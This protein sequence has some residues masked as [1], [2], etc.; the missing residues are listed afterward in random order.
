[1]IEEFFLGTAALLSS[2]NGMSFHEAE[3]TIPQGTFEIHSEMEF[4]SLSIFSQEE[5]LPNIEF[6][7]EN[8]EFEPWSLYEENEIEDSY[9]L[10][11]LFVGDPTNSI[12]IRSDKTANLVAHFY[13]TTRPG[14]KLVA[15]FDPFDDDS[16]DDPITGLS[17]EMNLKAPKYISRADW[18]ADESLRVWKTSKKISELFKTKWF[19]AEIA[20][21]PVK[22]RPKVVKQ[23]TEDGK[24]LYWPIA[25]SPH[26]AKFAIHHTG[27]Y[28][29]KERDPMEIMRAIYSFH[30]L[31]R[32]WGDIGYNYVIDKQGNIYEGRAGGPKSVGAHVAYHNIGTVGISLMGNFQTEK[33]TEAQ[34]KVLA[35]LLADHARRFDV[36]LTGK[37]E[38]FGKFT[39]NV[40]GHNEL[41]AAGHG[42]ACPGKYMIEKLPWLRKEAARYEDILLR[43]EK[44]GSTLGKDFLKKSK[45]APK[46]QPFKEFNIPDKKDPITISDFVEKQV[47]SRGERITIELSFRNNTKKAWPAK[48]E[49][50]ISNL[51]DGLLATKIR[52]VEKIGPGRTGVFRGTILVQSLENGNYN[53]ALKPIFLK[54][55]EFAKSI[56]D[57]YFELPIQVSGSKNFFTKGFQSNMLASSISM[58]K[59]EN[60]VNAPLSQ[61][62]TETKNKNTIQLPKFSQQPTIIPQNENY[63]PDV[64]VKL[65]FF[66]GKYTDIKGDEDVIVYNNDEKISLLKAGEK[67]KIV[68][69]ADKNKKSLKV[70]QGAKTW[71]LDSLS[72][73]TNGVLEVVHYDR[74]FSDTTKYNQFR[75]QLNIYPETKDKLLV[76]NQLPI[77][78]YLRGLA[79]EPSTEPNEK[80][81][82][83][84]VLARSYAYVYSGEQR[85]KFKTNLYD[86]EDDPATSQFYLGYDWERFHAHQTRLLNDTSGEVLTYNNQAV[87]GPYFTQSSGSSSSKWASQYPWTQ[88]RELPYDKGLEQKGHGVGL[89]GNSARKL[90]QK[91]HDYKEI[92]DYFFQNVEIEKKY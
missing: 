59:V 27:E 71:T 64:K 90:A 76:V 15:Q 24:P 54:E 37:S 49:M 30:T 91:G 83:I 18:G 13:N 19:D 3:I 72:L 50:I 8:G 33:P 80:K 32:G 40:A 16:H 12:V 85:R 44:R 57:I 48:S 84:H 34:L 23:T 87:I 89:S 51:P 2:G 75:S 77:E 79:E 21:V 5:E 88:G 29:K 55:R 41:A 73:K 38:F 1:M 52:S 9:S 39:N 65:K 20:A 35:L 70:T 10:D 78:L 62:P 61:R 53:L 68:I 43:N 4:N 28:V 74:K 7:N 31:T 92:I 56:E 86:L 63:G 42:T 22:Y 26:I 36:N 14:E 25:E 60:E 67:I 45:Y 82:A 17:K 66:E 6:Q 58:K 47:A 69:D 81:H 46:V 11:L